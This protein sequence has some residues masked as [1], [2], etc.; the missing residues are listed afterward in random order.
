[1]NPT[2]LG[3]DPGWSRIFSN[4][5]CSPLP[6]RDMLINLHLSHIATRYKPMT[7]S[8]LRV[9][10]DLVFHRQCPRVR[11][12]CLSWV[13]AMNRTWN[14]NRKM[15]LR[16]ALS[17]ALLATLTLVGCGG[18]KKDGAA[19]YYSNYHPGGWKTAHPGQ[20]LA[21]VNACTKCHEMSVIK[22]GSGI[23]TTRRCPD[24][25]TRASTGLGPRSPPIPPAPA[26]WPPARSA[27]ALIS[28]AEPP[29]AP[30]SPAM[31]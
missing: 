21:G 29:Q 12:A 23:P 8:F 24:G 11:V 5:L 28:R 25:P 31:G 2:P 7:L 17:F 26:A 10:N 20:A 13:P 18:A 6:G 16:G 22:V 4:P 9:M 15:S 1:M 14:W 19:Q 27:T 3:S 30:A